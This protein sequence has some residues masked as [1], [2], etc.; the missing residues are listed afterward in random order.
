LNGG[1]PT[2]R[3]SFVS[4]RHDV[5]AHAASLVEL[6]GGR[7]RAFWFSGSDE[8]ARDVE[9]LSATFFP[10]RGA[11]SEARSVADPESTKRALRRHV[12]KLGNPA[13]IRAADGILWLFYVTLSGVRK[14]WIRSTDDGETWSRPGGCHPAPEPQHDG[15]GR[16]SIRHG[17]WGAPTSLLR[18]G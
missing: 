1:E 10:E 7:L 3:T 9:I 16:R 18:V 5:T 15:E 2:F 4:R 17:T 12:T 13:A 6:G 8:G 14:L 11:W